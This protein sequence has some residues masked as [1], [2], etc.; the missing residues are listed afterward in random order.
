MMQLLLALAL[1]HPVHAERASVAAE[2]HRLSEEMRSL[3]MRSHWQGVDDHYQEL[4]ALRGAELTYDDH[5]LGAQASSALGDVQATWDRL[6]RALDVNFTDEA[7]TWWA[8]LSA[9]YGE[10]RL[11]VKPTY[12][13]SATLTIA[14]MPVALDQRATIEKAQQMLQEEGSYVGLLPLGQ[15]QLGERSFEVL[16]GPTVREVFK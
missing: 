13:G 8:T 5:W 10:V 15:Y 11:V 1:A 3:S 7:L 12:G 14:E 2:R 6:K 4:L 16:G 9:Q